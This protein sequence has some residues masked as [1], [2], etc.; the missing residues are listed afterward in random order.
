MKSSITQIEVGQRIAAVRKAKGLSQ[1]ELSRSLE[2]S[3]SSL[4]QVELG[5]RNLST[6]ELRKMSVVLGFSIDYFLGED[7][8]NEV[9][10]GSGLYRP[11]AVEDRISE[12][13]LNVVKVRTVLLYILERCAGNPN[14]GEE[15]LRKLLYFSDFN[16][17]E[18]YE[19]HLS[20]LSYR[21]LP[22]GPIPENLD[23]ILSRMV[24][25][26]D[27][28][29]VKS[30]YQD[31]SQIRYLPLRKADLTQLKA[32]ESE[33]LDKA[34]DQ[35]S[36]WSASSLSE[37]THQDIPW[38]TTRQG[39]LINYELAFYREAPYSVRQYRA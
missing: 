15:V 31:F 8:H 9:N 21:K 6:I 1:E 13:T 25:D 23:S 11:V 29:R 24:K 34:I 3:R 2:M 35:F 38:L 36:D 17:Y 37:Y 14:V 33:V 22:A 27:I 19:E 32:S 28:T 30:D 39:Q 5:N 12:P 16:Y 26:Q 4:A 20:G 18:L 7:F 10:E